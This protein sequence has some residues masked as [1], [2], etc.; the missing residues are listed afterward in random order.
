M[1][2]YCVCCRGG[3]IGATLDGESV[4][5]TWHDG[6]EYT[7][8]VKVC[9]DTGLCETDQL[10]PIQLPFV[11]PPTFRRLPPTPPQPPPTLPKATPPTP[12]QP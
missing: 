1:Y 3:D 4:S 10:D 6:E 12:P 9:T 11:P 5:Y 8:E 7:W 2:N